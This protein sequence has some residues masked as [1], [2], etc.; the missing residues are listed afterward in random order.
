MMFARVEDHCSLILRA[1]VFVLSFISRC[2]NA[3]AYLLCYS[4]AS[5][6]FT[7]LMVFVLSLISRCVDVRACLLRFDVAPD[8]FTGLVILVFSLILCCVDVCAPSLFCYIF[9][10]NTKRFLSN[11][12]SSVDGFAS[13]GFVVNAFKL[14]DTGLFWLCLS[15]ICDQKSLSKTPRQKG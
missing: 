1:P 2:V 6:A 4:V 3:R 11:C 7:R 8:T 13:V 9:L 5:D 14:S 15:A 12:A 10:T